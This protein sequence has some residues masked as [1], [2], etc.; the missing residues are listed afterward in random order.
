MKP[1]KKEQSLILACSE[2][3]A[4]NYSETI[5]QKNHDDRIERRKYCPSCAR[6]TIHRETR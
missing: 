6:H 5:N 2:C 3:Q 1:R 4:R